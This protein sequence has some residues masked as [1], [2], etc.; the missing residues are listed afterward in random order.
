MIAE[1]VEQIRVDEAPPAEQVGRLERQLGPAGGFTG[2]SSA[3]RLFTPPPGPPENM[4]QETLDAL[5]KHVQQLRAIRTHTLSPE[6]WGAPSAA[7]AGSPVVLATR[8]TSLRS[9]PRCA[10]GSKPSTTTPSPTPTA[11][12]AAA[13]RPQVIPARV[14]GRCCQRRQRPPGRPRPWPRAGQVSTVRQ[15][16]RRPLPQ[17]PPRGSP[18]PQ[19]HQVRRQ[20][21]QGPGRVRRHPRTGHPRRRRPVRPRVQGPPPSL[22]PGPGPY[23]RLLSES[24]AADLKPLPAYSRLDITEI[25]SDGSAKNIR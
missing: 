13:S 12:R 16:P 20:P 3:S 1:A 25:E 17:G 7:S 8:P 24:W 5:I 15:Q 18:R 19:D 6:L 9:L 23:V 11:A 21:A 4:R 10:P 2:A 14:R 22:R